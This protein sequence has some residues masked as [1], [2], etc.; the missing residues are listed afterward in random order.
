MT[1]LKYSGLNRPVFELTVTGV[2][3]Q[4]EGTTLPQ[5]DA[6]RPPLRWAVV[7]T[8]RAGTASKALGRRA[9]LPTFAGP[10]APP[11]A[12]VA[13]AD[14]VEDDMEEGDTVSESSDVL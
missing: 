12:P 13:D 14:E 4:W 9:H 3:L 2:D 7:L 11:A 1:H 8:H 10:A 6:Q 5:E